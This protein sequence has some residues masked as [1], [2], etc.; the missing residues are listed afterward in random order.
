[1]FKILN[2]SGEYERRMEDKLSAVAA[3]IKEVLSFTGDI[4]KMAVTIKAA[5]LFVSLL[6]QKA[7]IK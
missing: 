3:F 5:C 4:L 1:M 7:K 2:E 6:Y